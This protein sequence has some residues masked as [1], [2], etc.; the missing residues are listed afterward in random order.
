MRSTLPRPQLALLGV[1]ALFA[2]IS[3]I[4]SPY[5]DL[6]PLQN[7]P[8]LVIV[9]GL[10]LALRFRP[11]PNSAVWCLCAFLWLHTVG[12]RYA[13]SYVPYDQWFSALGL[14]APSAVFGLTRN[15]YDRVVHF[16]FGLLMVHPI[17]EFL[18]R[19]GWVSRAVAL[20]IAVEFVFA[21]SA[22][23]EIFEWLLT[24]VMAGPDA[25]AYN[26]QQGDTWDAQKDMACAVTGALSAAGFLTLRRWQRA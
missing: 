16:S 9:S 14:P 17:A 4:G 1:T 11:L 2:L 6:A 5:P 21:G 8:T 25:N 22:L 24:L 12:G 10:A 3:L 15:G 26:G 7:L 13:Y 19:S 18:E 20:Y 23:Y